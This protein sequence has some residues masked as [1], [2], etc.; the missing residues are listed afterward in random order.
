LA[1]SYTA[2]DDEIERFSE[3]LRTLDDHQLTGDLSRMY[4]YLKSAEH[5]VE[6]IVQ[7][8]DTNLDLVKRKIGAL[9]EEMGRRKK[10]G[11]WIW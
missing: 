2:A 6:P 9:E 3:S 1:G 7:D 8:S 5:G 11:V 4:H 10:E